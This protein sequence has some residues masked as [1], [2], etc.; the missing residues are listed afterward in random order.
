MRSLMS[1]R[2]ESRQTLEISSLSA[3]EH[4]L[5]HRPER[6]RHLILFASPHKLK[7][8]LSNLVLL[9]KQHRIHLEY[10][11]QEKQEI[12]ARA[13]LSP[14]EYTDFEELRMA[15]K[16]ANTSL[17]LALD[18]LQDP[19]N[20]GALCRSADAFG[21]AGIVI[22]KDRSVTVS[23]GVY[24]A[25]VG[26]VDTV[27]ITLVTNLSEALRKLKKD[28]YWMVGT[29]LGNPGFLKDH[30]SLGSPPWEIPDFQ[31]I[32]LLLGSELEGV[33]PSLQKLFDWRVEIPLSGKVQSLNVSV[34][35]AVLM[36]EIQHRARSMV[37]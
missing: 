8:R 9:A 15:R 30:A 37:E 13:I 21:A 33:S 10:S 11:G 20:F 19:Q 12:L 1:T 28:G 2:R 22:P 34:A 17:I 29:A 35:G 5:T 7:A 14:F 3:I 32:V 23:T 24:H 25:S 36:Y 18:H 16:T 31:K 4:I 6:I 26:A 27:P